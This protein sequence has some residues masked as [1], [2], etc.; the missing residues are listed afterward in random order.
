W[1]AAAVHPL[2]PSQAAW[3]RMV[4]G[5]SFGIAAPG[6]RAA[7]ETGAMDRLFVAGDG[8]PA[9]LGVPP[10]GVYEGE[11]FPLPGD[12]L[13]G[14]R[15]LLKEALRIVG[16]ARDGQPIGSDAISRR[17]R[18]ARDIL[19]PLAE[20]LAGPAEA[21]GASLSMGPFAEERRQLLGLDQ[22]MA[23]AQS[24]DAVEAITGGLARIIDALGD[25]AQA[26]AGVHLS[27]TAEAACG[28]RLA[29]RFKAGSADTPLPA[30]RLAA[31]GRAL[32]R[33]L[34]GGYPQLAGWLRSR[35]R[36]LAQRMAETDPSGNSR[37]IALEDADE[38]ARGW[39][40]RLLINPVLPAPAWFALFQRLHNVLLMALSALKLELYGLLHRLA[41]AAP[42]ESPA[43]DGGGGTE[44]AGSRE[45]AEY[46]LNGCA[47][48]LIDVTIPRHGTLAVQQQWRRFTGDV[49]FENGL[50][51]PGAAYRITSALRAVN[52]LCRSSPPSG[53]AAPALIAR[54]HGLLAKQD[55][56]TADGI[57][58]IRARIREGVVP[59]SLK[60]IDGLGDATVRRLLVVMLE[61]VC[62]GYGLATDT[63]LA[64]AFDGW[65]AAKLPGCAGL[66]ALPA[67]VAG[68]I[69]AAKG[70]GAWS[71]EATATADAV[72][73]GLWVS[74]T[75]E[76]HLEKR[77]SFLRECFGG[78]DHPLRFLTS[79]P[80]LAASK[81]PG[82][83]PVIDGPW[84][85]ALHLDHG[86]PRQGN[87][88]AEAS[89][90]VTIRLQDGKAGRPP[91]E[92]LAAAASLIEDWLVTHRSGFALT[93]DG[94]RLTVV[95]NAEVDLG[96]FRYRPVGATL[97]VTAAPQGGPPPSLIGGLPVAALSDT[98]RSVRENLAQTDDCA[99]HSRLAGT[100][101]AL[102]AASLRT[103]APEGGD[104]SVTAL[105][106]GRCRHLMLSS[107]ELAQG[108]AADY[109]RSYYPDNAFRIGLN[110]NP[111]ETALRLSLPPIEEEARRTLDLLVVNQG[112]GG[113]D[114]D[115]GPLLSPGPWTA[116]ALAGSVV[117]PL[118]ASGRTV[119]TV[120][121]DFPFSVQ[122]LEVFAP[123]CAGEGRIVATLGDGMEPIIDRGM[124]DAIRPAL[125]QGDTD[126][127]RDAIDARVAAMTAAA[128]GRMHLN[129]FLTASDA[130]IHD[131][132]ASHP[133][134]RDA[135]SLLRC[136]KPVGDVLR[137][138]DTP[139]DRI[140]EVLQALRGTPLPRSDFAAAEQSLLDAFPT[141]ARE[142][143]A[144]TLARFQEVLRRRV[145]AVL[146]D[147]AFRIGLDPAWLAGRPLYGPAPD[148]LWSLLSH[149]W[150]NI[151]A[152][153]PG[154]SR[155]PARFAVF[156]RGTGEIRL[157]TMAA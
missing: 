153:D 99:V 100:L 123:L 138:P 26:A 14:A 68:A 36:A 126:S 17:L 97:S 95:W 15:Q 113:R 116:E 114:A 156:D 82:V 91:D 101:N 134:G 2:Q 54:L 63:A 155:G 38:S 65:F 88:A 61:Q 148:S 27:Y 103:G 136:L 73:F 69:E 143:T 122:M 7:V 64:A 125:D 120:V 48:V 4:R 110:G 21:G 59:R 108:A 56:A 96:P 6:A 62:Q 87:G 57:A 12:R 129:D 81:G 132:L 35:M 140:D 84:A 45:T 29:V 154:L 86:R 41:G 133:G 52:T 44:K 8:T 76:S 145:E 93:R 71:D 49:R 117:A 139:L 18:G 75:L 149:R 10:G 98:I 67:T 1:T 11:R 19:L 151:L 66:A 94:G 33:L 131:H 23:A 39:A 121:L 135:V 53:N 46:G 70:Q 92:V 3:L 137:N 31:A 115:G 16:E 32:T 102:T 74:A 78:T 47:A 112:S 146:S 111:A 51:R 72:G 13:T 34:N 152:L 144:D 147:P 119:R 124:W 90:P 106:Q 37:F 107:A 25:A 28:L 55:Q 5:A 43:A 77:A 22:D 20:A 130:A 127:L 150:A 80:S 104:P 60:A 85:A 118:T 50:P 24:W 142:M 30:D 157:V 141:S 109:P 89:A 40:V 42:A 58:A 79:L 128:V 105:R 83:Q 9:L